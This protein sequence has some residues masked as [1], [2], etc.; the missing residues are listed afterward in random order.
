MVKPRATV[1][2]P[3]KGVGTTST[4]IGSGVQ[5]VTRADGAPS[6]QLQRPDEPERAGRT[7]A[8]FRAAATTGDDAERK[9]LQDQAAIVNMGVARAIASR[10]HDRG[11]SSEDLVQVAYLGLLKAVRGFD[12]SFDRDFLSYA[13][14]TITGEVKRH[15]RD[16]GWSVRPPRRI[17][18]LQGEVSRAGHEL[19][20]RLGQNP[21]PAQVAEHLGVD[22]DQVVE[23]LGAD[24]CFTPAS[25]D[26]PVGEDGTSSLGELLGAADGDLDNV[27]ARVVLA[28]VVSRLGD[29][30]RRILLLRFFRGW[31]QEQ[32]ATDIGVTQMQV[33][34]LLARILADLRRQIAP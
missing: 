30:D 18:E 28:P 11:V 12:P 15:F 20:Q 5:P 8:L 17:Q 23:A 25:L 4:V 7:E 27:E 10:Y 16:H 19:T 26:V 13:V 34:R 24:G 14:P 32:I 33:S 22:V 31:T 1:G 9:R 2:S 29:R 3:E 21:T 6:F